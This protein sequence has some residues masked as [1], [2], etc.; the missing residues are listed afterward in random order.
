MK[1]KMIGKKGFIL[2][3]ITL[4]LVLS[5]CSSSNPS[6]SSP[7][8]SLSNEEKSATDKPNSNEKKVITLSVIKSTRFLELAKEK[9]EAANPTIKIEIKP[10]YTVPEVSGRITVARGGGIN[11]VEVEKFVTTVNAE[12]MN[13]NASDIIAVDELAYNKYAE[14]GL[15]TNLIDF[16]DKTNG[17]NQDDYFMNVLDAL[18]NKDGLYALPYGVMTS[19]WFGNQERLAGL[20]LDPAKAWTWDEF[21]KKMKTLANDGSKDPLVRYL[22]PDKLLLEMV[23]KDMDKFLDVNEKKAKFQDQAFIDMLKQAKSFY[24]L[25]IISPL[26]QPKGPGKAIKMGESLGLKDALSLSEI[27]T[28]SSLSFASM[29]Y[30]KPLLYQ[31][32]TSEPKDGNSFESNMLL[33]INNKSEN[34]KEAWSF[35]QFLISEEMQSSPEL[36]GLPVNKKASQAQIDASAANKDMKLSPEFIEAAKELL[37]QLKRYSGLDPKIKKILID[38]TEP[39]FSGQKSAETV[40]N[41]IQN[42]VSLYLE[43]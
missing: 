20:N 22:N 13:G 25:K 38:E 18:K 43:E 28:Y 31:A 33:S 14:K 2:S 27:T 35:L 16:M 3:L 30:D 11:P 6:A 21:E 17:F 5:A 8:N 12:L 34:K 15:L 24:D 19:V 4:M 32:P 26:E 1:H 39:F 29:F 41:S 7:V 40:A 37:P 10:S 36:E 9:F 23:S 42:K